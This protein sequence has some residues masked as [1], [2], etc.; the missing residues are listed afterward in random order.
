MKP[1]GIFWGSL[2]IFL[3]AFF[4][5]SN[6]NICRIEFSHISDYWPLLLIIWGA[7][8]L[9]IPILIKNIL[10]SASA[11]LLALLIMGFFS[12]SWFP[13]TGSHNFHFHTKHYDRKNFDTSTYQLSIPMDTTCRRATFNFEGG[14][15]SF[16]IGD[17]TSKMVEVSANG[18]VTNATLQ[19]DTSDNMFNI[20]YSYDIDNVVWSHKHHGRDMMIRL[21][22]N[23]IWNLDFEIGASKLQADFSPYKVNKVS[24][25]AGA[26][27]IQLKFGDLADTLNVDVEVGASAVKF[28]VP[29]QAGCEI[30]T[31]TGLSSSKFTGFSQTSDDHYL[32]ENFQSANKK[33]FIKI[34]AG[35]SNFKVERY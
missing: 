5:L 24:I 14:V 31:E 23:I 27:D 26:A 15:G 34:S 2:L 33:I 1:S 29:K 9:K 19:T 22:R 30:I 7:S 3:G 21:N 35:V 17:S 12:F 20:H 6:F 25:D 8:L 16:L 18:N 4:L 11:L 28:F 10:A 32:T 13:F